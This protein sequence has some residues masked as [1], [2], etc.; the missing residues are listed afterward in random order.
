MATAL[1]RINK[2]WNAFSR[3]P[4]QYIPDVGRSYSLNPDRPYFTGGN[5]R[6]IVSALYN[7][8]ALDVS[9]LTIRHCRLNS[10]GQY[11][12]EI[13]DSLDDCLNVAANIDQTGR[14]FIHDLTTTMFD[15]GVAA[16]VPVKTSDDPNSFGS[17]DIY[18]LRVGRIIAWMPQHVRVSVYNDG[19]GQ[20]E[21]LVLPKTWVA[22]VENPLYSVMNEP[23]S[24]LQ[25]LIRKLNLLDAIDNQSS[26]GKLD[27]ILQ[28]PYTIKSDARR[29]EAERRRSDIEKQLT[30]S[31]YGV[32][33]TDGAERVIQLNRSVD[34][35][36]LDQIK[37]LSPMLYGQLGVSEAIAN[38]TATPEEMLNYYNRTIEPII[39]SICDA[40][41]AKFLTKTARSQGQTIKFFRD[42]FKL[43]P[44]DQIA[45]LADKFT[46][47]EIMTSN[48]FRSVLGMSRVD[49]PAADELRNKNL[50]KADSGSDQSGLGDAED[51]DAMTQEQYDAE[52]ARFDQ[53]DKDL[54]ELERQTQ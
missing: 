14:Q 38:G 37:Y 2:F 6:S 23:N 29:K 39:A 19:S 54:D 41:N 17:Y 42:P 52:I 9:A 32:A 30:D 35:N 34:N 7:R 11:V 24:T 43:A 1:T 53:N 12:E 3:P 47:N 48:E 8:V 22:I 16:A 20:R 25:R 28:L 50:N 5:E 44:V 21:E 51:E 49:D 27:L 15:D 18:E 40:M 33:Y 31:K 10:Q 13:R 26:S 36:L 46:R 4:G 45:E